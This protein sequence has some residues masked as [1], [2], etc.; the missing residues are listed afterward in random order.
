MIRIVDSVFIKSAVKIQDYPSSEFVDIA[1]AGKSNVGKSSMIN[2]I[3]KRKKIAKVSSTPGKT[4]L[5]NFFKITCKTESND[6]AYFNLV[7][8]PGYGFAKVSKKE[9][10]SWKKMI[11]D[12]FTSR[13]QLRG[14][15]ILIDIR[16]KADEKDKVMINMAKERKIPY[17]VAATKADKIPKS[18]I[19]TTI[20]QRSVEHQINESEIIAF[21]SLK[22]IG[23]N[24]LLTWM[25]SRTL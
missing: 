12:Y 14:I 15:V 11:D 3:L 23:Y 2:T 20:K 8:L 24:D 4:K 22:N 19:K 6:N 5:V 25:E 18:K 1:F 7:D 10:N 13:I 21:S 9:K 16:H 17:L